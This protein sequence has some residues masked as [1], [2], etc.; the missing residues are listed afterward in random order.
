[1]IRKLLVLV[2]AVAMPAAAMAGI[3]AV[4]GAGIASAGKPKP[5]PVAETCNLNGTVTFAK[6]GLSFDG[7]LTK[8][9]VEDTKT[10]ITLGTGSST[11]CSATAIKNTIVTDPTPCIGLYPTVP[12]VTPP[13]ITPDNGDAW[14]CYLEANAKIESKGETS[15]FDTASSLATAGVSEIVTSL[16]AGIK[17]KDNA[18]NVVLAVTS[19]GT[20]AV[21]PPG[22]GTPYAGACGENVGFLLT[23]AVDTS[24]GGAVS[25]GGSP[26]SYTLTICLVGDTGSAATTG[27]FFADYLGAASGNT[28]ITVATAALNGTTADGDASSLVVS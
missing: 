23:G 2:A 18:V 7:T 26:A 16:G 21:E 9:T 28:A 27:N 5:V 10:D 20:Y 25:I 11:A 6:P 8:K 19:G 22:T 1:M 24:T 17:T 12:T 3:T 4:S 13:S 15:Y 14:A